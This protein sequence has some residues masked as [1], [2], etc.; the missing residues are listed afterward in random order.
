[1]YRKFVIFFI[2]IVPV[3]L[4]SSESNQSSFNFDKLPFDIQAEILNYIVGKN[5][6][7]DDVILARKS[8]YSLF[9][10]GKAPGLAVKG[11]INRKPD[12]K[13]I[14]GYPK[15][16]IEKNN[17]ITLQM[18]C[19]ENYL[20]ENKKRRLEEANLNSYSTDYD[21]DNLNNLFCD[22]NARKIMHKN[23]F[24]RYLRLR[25]PLEQ[26]KSVIKEELKEVISFVMPVVVAS[27]IGSSIGIFKKYYL[28]G[29]IG[30]AKSIGLVCAISAYIS[31]SYGFGA[32]T[33]SVRNLYVSCVYSKYIPAQAVHQ[34][35][36]H[37]AEYM[38]SHFKD[39]D[40]LTFNKDYQI[41]AISKDILRAGLFLNKRFIRED[42]KKVWGGI[43]N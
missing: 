22:M 3:C 20:I 10:T 39:N 32:L 28:S 11:I 19:S 16:I 8:L 15:P 34:A 14:L 43:K 42:Y 23:F 7:P 29:S 30:L 17:W 33:V 26:F 12:L 9:R 13:K 4:K 5:N 18:L 6:D 40:C 38:S 41:P 27:G 21:I 35:I 36:L 1:M 31:L 24:S 37:R 2:L 25:A